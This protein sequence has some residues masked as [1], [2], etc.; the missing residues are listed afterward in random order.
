M[1]YRCGDPI[2][3]AIFIRSVV[4]ADIL[5]SKPFGKLL[6]FR[7]ELLNGILLFNLGEELREAIYR[8]LAK[9][10]LD[11]CLELT[12]LNN[13]STKLFH[14]YIQFSRTFSSNLIE[15]FLFLDASSI[16]ALS[17]FDIKQFFL[18]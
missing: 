6:V 1:V 14:I 8:T 11:D 17:S 16:R 5:Y 13:T 12:L 7:T 18:V 3:L 2:R 15:L 9:D 10:Q 4:E